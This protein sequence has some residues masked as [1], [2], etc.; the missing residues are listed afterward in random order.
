M[1]CMIH[2]LTASDVYV[3][4]MAKRSHFNDENTENLANSLLLRK[5]KFF[6]HVK[7]NVFTAPM[8]SL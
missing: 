4:R 5:K 2:N 8:L 7:Y 1:V 3:N 6:L